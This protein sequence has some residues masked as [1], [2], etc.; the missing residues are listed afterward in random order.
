LKVKTD[1]LQILCIA[2]AILTQSAQ[3]TDVTLGSSTS[4]GPNTFIED[5]SGNGSFG[6]EEIWNWSLDYTYTSVKD[7]STLT[8]AGVPVVEATKDFRGGMGWADDGWSLT[9]NLEY[10][11][12]PDEDLSNTGLLVNLSKRTNIGERGP[13]GF[14]PWWSGKLSVSGNDYRQV[15]NGSVNVTK[16]K[17]KPITGENLLNQRMLKGELKFRLLKP[18]S[19]KVSASS[20]SYNRSVADF[21]SYLNSSSASQRGMASLGGT[22]GGL[23]ASQAA[24]GATWYFLEDW[25]LTADY[26]RSILA[27]DRSIST[28]TRLQL[29]YD[30]GDNWHF[31]AGEEHDIAESDDEWLTLATIEY[32]F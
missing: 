24:V 19:F 7:P 2:M 18:L 29:E 12:T 6:P 21:D 15:F 11:V 31:A 1:P 30:C 23:P 16:K 9:G 28:V 8:T 20:Y 22:V 25:D 5:V 27:A 4:K 32:T 10:A 14:Q 17:V 3:A 13:N 26:S